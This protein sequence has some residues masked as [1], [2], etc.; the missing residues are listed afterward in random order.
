MTEAEFEQIFR[1]HFNVMANIAYS[2]VKDHDEARDITQQVFIKFWDKRNDVDIQDNIK[3]YLHRAVVNTSLNHIE[4]TKRIQLEEDV[5]SALK[6]QY[7]ELEKPEIKEGEIEKAIEKVVKNLP[8]KCQVVFSLSRYDGMTNKEI[9]EYLDVSIKAVE[10]HISR[11]LREL[12]EK[13]KPYNN[14]IR[15]L[16]LFEVGLHFFNLLLGYYL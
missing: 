5:Q 15:I 16:I 11:A 8:D 7:F 13:L 9:A 1:T 10:K 4:K 6:E 2:V 3:A 14:L 12:R